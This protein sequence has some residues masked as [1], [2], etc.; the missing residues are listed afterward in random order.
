MLRALEKVTRFNKLYKILLISIL[1]YAISNVSYAIDNKWQKIAPGVEYL[2]LNENNLINISHIHVF[3]IDLKF[4]KLNLTLANNLTNKQAIVSEFAAAANA[5]I[6]LNGGFFDTKFQP[7]GLRIAN[8]HKYNPIKYISWWGI[9]YIKNNKAKITTVNNFDQSSNIDFAVQSGPRLVINGNIP[10]LKPGFA[11]R[12]ALGITKDGKIIVLVTKN[13]PIT[14]TYLANL[15]KSKPLNCFNAIN[16]DGG[17]SSQLYA[18][19]N[20][21]KINSLGFSEISD[22]ILIQKK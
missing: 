22:A 9:F 6:A 7:L 12:S 4:N 11:E 10:S 8:H 19:F 20:N 1:V 15:M 18:N 17:S 2:D 5:I 21:L 16:L 14:T 3:K 13:T